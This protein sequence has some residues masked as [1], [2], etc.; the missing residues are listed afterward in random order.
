A[1]AYPDKQLQEVDAE[2]LRL[3]LNTHRARGLSDHTLHV[4]YRDL[5]TF[6]HW[7]EREELLAVTPM[8]KMHPPMLPTLLPKVLS[9]DQI[10]YVLLD[11]GLRASECAH[12]TLDDI[13]LPNSFLM[14]R[15]GKG[16]KDRAIP[17]SN[18]LRKVLW[19]YLSETRPKFYPSTSALFF[20][21]T[22]DPISTHA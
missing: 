11:T 10:I 5:N 3:Y 19:K 4:M 12:L 13:H 1:A 17:I 20:H 2:L 15:K 8:R 18:T 21:R 16:G 14:V 6:F 7:C 22:G 9:P